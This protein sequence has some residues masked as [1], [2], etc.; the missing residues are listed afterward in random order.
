MRSSPSSATGSTACAGTRE[1]RSR[2]DRVRAGDHRRPRW[3]PA[4][5]G[6][7]RAREAAASGAPPR[8]AGLPRSRGT[9]AAAAGRDARALPAGAP[10]AA[11]VVHGRRQDPRADGRDPGAPVHLPAGPRISRVHRACPARS[12][13]GVPGARAVCR[14][15]RVLGVLLD[16]ACALAPEAPKLRRVRAT[17]R[18]WI[19]RSAARPRRIGRGPRGATR[20][21]RPKW[22]RSPRGCD[23]W[24]PRCPSDWSRSWRGTV[25][26]STR[27]TR[28]PPRARSCS[29]TSL[30]EGAGARSEFA[31]AKARPPLALIGPRPLDLG[32]PDRG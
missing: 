22:L 11:R 3:C 18:V 28:A 24:T 32:R 20:T 14:S 6:Q 16:L 19:G 25:S 23:S 27:S 17:W 30:T 15:R 29:G 12:R 21:T 2:V 5:C 26:T 31:L 7:R 4:G 10:G 9:C 8:L 13:L 1:R